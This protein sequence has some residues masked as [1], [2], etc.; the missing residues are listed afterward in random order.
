LEQKLTNEQEKRLTAENNLAQEK[1][2]S[3]NLRQQLQAEKQN[4]QTLQENYAN[5]KQKLSQQ[6]QNHTN[7]QNIYQNAI[8]DKQTTETLIQSEKQNAFIQKQRA[9]HYENQL[10][11]IAKALHQ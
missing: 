11:S 6:E 4:N 3:H 8:K 1:Q 9:D 10:K 2:I 7:L 5:L